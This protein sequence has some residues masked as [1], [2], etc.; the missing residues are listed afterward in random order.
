LGRRRN[1]KTNTDSFKTETKVGG[2]V[3]RREDDTTAEGNYTYCDKKREN[4]RK[5]PKDMGKIR[6]EGRGNGARNEGGAMKREKVEAVRVSGIPVKG[7][8]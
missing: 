8:S 7:G 6:R 2:G 1:R 4:L 5:N 3:G